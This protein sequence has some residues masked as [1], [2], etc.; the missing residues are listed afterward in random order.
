MTIPELVISHRP[1]GTPVAAVCS[2]C[3]EW[4]A[5]DYPRPSKP[6]DAITAF[7]EQF[8]IHTKTKHPKRHAR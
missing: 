4:M 1:D 3:G 8:K 7:T 2:L 5:V 6:E